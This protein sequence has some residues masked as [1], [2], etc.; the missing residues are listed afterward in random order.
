MGIVL[1]FAGAVL[2]LVGILSLSRSIKWAR[3]KPWRAVLEIIVG[4]LVILYS[5]LGFFQ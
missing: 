4:G 3:V 5:I 2:L 1:L